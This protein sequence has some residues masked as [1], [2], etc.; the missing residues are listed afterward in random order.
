MNSDSP[1]RFLAVMIV[2]NDWT[3]LNIIDLL[4]VGQTLYVIR[5]DYVKSIALP[6]MRATKRCGASPVPGPIRFWRYSMR[7]TYC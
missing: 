7:D 6:A 1:G 2:T 4:V 3:G 5:L